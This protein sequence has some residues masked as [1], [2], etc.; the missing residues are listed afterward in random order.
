MCEESG[1]AEVGCLNQDFRGI[2]RFAGC[3]A[4]SFLLRKKLV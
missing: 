4:Q 2:L 3:T 1:G